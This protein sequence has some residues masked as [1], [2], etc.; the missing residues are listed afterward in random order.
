MLAARDEKI[1]DLEE[2]KIEA[3]TRALFVGGAGASLQSSKDLLA[4]VGHSNVNPQ[5]SV[6]QRQRLP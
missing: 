2:A 1:I 3:E 5:Q 4:Q 6:I